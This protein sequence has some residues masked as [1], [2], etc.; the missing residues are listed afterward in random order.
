[1]GVPDVFELLEQILHAPEAL[2]RPRPSAVAAGSSNDGT[3]HSQRTGGSSVNLDAVADV[4]HVTGRQ[5]PTFASHFEPPW[6]WLEGVDG[7]GGSLE[8]K[9]HLRAQPHRLQF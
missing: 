2:V 7:L 4:E 3:R 9:G 1:M 6:V 5:A 8:F